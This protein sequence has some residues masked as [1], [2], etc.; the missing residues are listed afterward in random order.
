M[1][2]GMWRAP[3]ASY[4]PPPMP[5]PSW[6]QKPQRPQPSKPFDSNFGQPITAGWFGAGNGGTVD[7]R[8]KDLQ[9][10]SIRIM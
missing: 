5:Y 3:P 4:G 10:A 6:A 8:S 7:Q 1:P 9:I 2:D